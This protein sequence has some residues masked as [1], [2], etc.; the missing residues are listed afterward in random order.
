[1]C[2]IVGFLDKRGGHDRPVGRTILAMLEALG[3]RG[4]DSAG[5]AIF[6]TPRG[7][8]VMRVKLPEDAPLAAG[9][10]AVLAALRDSGAVLRHTVVGACV[11]LEVDVA[12]DTDSLESTLLRR[13]PGAEVVSLGC[14]LQIAKQVGSPDQL[15]RTYGVSQW[16]GT[17]GIGHTRLSTESRVDLSHSQPFWAH[18]VP[19][20][21]TVHNGHITNYHKLRRLYEQRGHR[22]F[23]ENDSEVI[24]VYLRDRLAAGLS[25]EDALRSSLDDFDGSFCYLAASEDRLAYV[26]DRFG[27]KP[28]VVAETD[29]FVAIATEEIALRKALGTDFVAREPAP[30]TMKVWAA[31]A[32]RPAHAR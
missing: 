1:L 27:F 32:P 11:R 12:A 21:A 13:V 9:E 25:L 7:G 8:C 24:G 22:F 30:G 18:G 20:L 5:V 29:A 19:D 6:G 16:T 4:P 10:A 3:C 14:R 26:R 31:V 23:T 15:E 17:H 28:L 2:G